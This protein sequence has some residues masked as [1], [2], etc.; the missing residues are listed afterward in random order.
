MQFLL[1]FLSVYLFSNHH[2][3]VVTSSLLALC[4]AIFLNGFVAIKNNFLLHDIKQ[5][6]EQIK[7]EIAE[8]TDVVSISNKLAPEQLDSWL[9]SSSNHPD[10][11]SYAS[12]FYAWASYIA[13]LRLNDEWLAR[14]YSE[15][16]KKMMESFILLKPY[17]AY[18]YASLAKEE[19]RNGA[20]YM[21]I[22]GLIDLSKKQ[23][24]YEKVTGSNSLEFY[25]AFWP[26]LTVDD[27]EDAISMIFNGSKYG[28]NEYHFRRILT[29]PLLKMRFCSI[30]KFGGRN[31][32]GCD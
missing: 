7:Y 17:D 10:Y 3:L 27:K 8:T 11:F 22:K 14:E 28:L 1:H 26:M 30:T 31:F 21:K 12:N 23:G 19:W 9:S 13:T 15:R 6:G 5:K 25:L 24:P 32:N 2:S 18:G 4:L 29:Q 20:S 16:S